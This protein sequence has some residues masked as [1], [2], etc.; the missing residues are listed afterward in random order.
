MFIGERQWRAD[1]EHVSVRSGA[2]DEDPGLAQLL[3]DACGEL[4]ARELDAGEETAASH[5]DHVG[6][7]ERLDRRAQ[8][9]SHARGPL[10]QP[11]VL[12]HVEHGERRGCS[13]RVAAE[14]GER[15]ARVREPLGELP[16]RHDRRDRIAVAHRLAERDD[17]RRDAVPRERPELRPEPAVARLHLVRDVEPSRGMRP[18]HEQLELRAL[19]RVDPVA[20]QR[21]VE[22]RRGEIVLELVERARARSAPLPGG[23]IRITRAGGC[24]VGQSSGESRVVAAVTPW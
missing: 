12:E 2:P 7:A 19:G 13:D 10:G 3:A 5:L 1:L 16:P 9:R 11:L 23:G 8:A 14:G 20:H 22:K 18:L 24:A 15:P 4:A 21:P 6:L 17:V